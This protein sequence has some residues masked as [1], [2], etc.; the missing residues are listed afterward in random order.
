MKPRDVLITCLWILV[1]AIIGATAALALVKFL[2]G[3]T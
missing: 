1:S 2:V 3:L